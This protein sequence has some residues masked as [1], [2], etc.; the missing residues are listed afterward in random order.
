MRPRTASALVISWK[1]FR[2]LPVKASSTSGWEVV[3]SMSW[4]V[5]ESF[6]SPPV[7]SGTGFA[8]SPGLYFIR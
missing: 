3:G 5:P 4:R 2:P 8:L 1:R 6:R 7:I